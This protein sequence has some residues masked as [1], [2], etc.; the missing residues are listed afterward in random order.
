[1]QNTYKKIHFILFLLLYIPGD[2][3]MIGVLYKHGAKL[4]H[5]DDFG[6]TPLCVACIRNCS[7][8]A[9]FLIK[10]KSNVNIPDA[11][12]NLPIHYTARN[13]NYDLTKLLIDNGSEIDIMNKYS[14]SPLHM[15][16]RNDRLEI[17]RELVNHNCN[18]N[19]CGPPDN[20][21]A[22]HIAVHVTSERET[23][24]PILELLIKG[25]V[26][27]NAKAFPLDETPLH[28]ALE[29]GKAEVALLLLQCGA[30][31]NIECPHDITVL[32]KACRKEFLEIVDV[33]IHSGLDWE[34]EK[35]LYIDIHNSG[36]NKDLL[37]EYEEGDIPM[38][39][40][41]NIDLFFY[42]MEVKNSVMSLARLSRLAIRRAMG[43]RV[44]EG[45]EQVPLPPKLKDF[46]MLKIV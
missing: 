11:K 40:I 33:V 15:A 45:V 28:R 27:L 16:V 12:M 34:K 13:G 6:M 7:T 22:L 25:G 17:I 41:H 14:E 42:I 44:S 9:K 8:V 2:L 23:V 24:W 21:T 20:A 46:L 36:I 1:M 37:V 10:C 4:N 29:I 31:P 18:V 32:Q 30:D 43:S 39:L 35:W 19:I 5:C 3:G 26:D 38:A